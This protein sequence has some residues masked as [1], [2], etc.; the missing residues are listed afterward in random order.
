[1]KT[2]SVTPADIEQRWVVVD[3]KDKSLGRLASEIARLLMGKHKVNCVRHLPCGDIVVVVNAEKVVM[4]GR[5]W[6]SKFY[7]RHS[8]YI[9]GLKSTSAKD[10]RADHP[11]RII[12]FAVK[13]MLPNN[14]LRS[15]LLG[16]LKVYAGENHPHAAQKPVAPSPRL[17]K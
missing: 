17:A 16:N 2:Q 12:S 1:M 8:G 15:K 4:T 13:G 7:H 10:M 9:G 6:D 11:D 14:K 5:K 3:A